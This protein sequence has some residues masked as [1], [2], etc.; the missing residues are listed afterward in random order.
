MTKVFSNIPFFRILIPFVI[1]I[2]LSIH[3][4]LQPISFLYLLILIALAFAFRVKQQQTFL[5]KRLFLVCLD[6]FF[7]LFAIN[8]VSKTNL[9][10]Q[11][12]YYGNYISS[13]DSATNLIVTVNDLPVEKERFIK[14]QVKVN[15][16]R[17]DS[18]YQQAEGSIIAYFK[19]PF[20][21][22]KLK[23]GT[24]L[25]IKAKLLEIEPPKNPYEFDYKNYLYNK[26][27]Y[28][29][30]FIDQNAFE[31]L[32]VPI[33]LNTIWYHGL[34][35]KNY[36]LQKLK[37]SALSNDA[38]GICAALLTGYDDEIDKQ[39]IESFSHSGTLHV[40]SVSGLH[41]GLI[42]L[43]LS[44]LFD[45]I[46]KKKKY[47]IFKFL[48]ITVL[49]WCFALITGFSAPVLRAVIMFNLLGFGKIFFRADQRIQVNI[50][51]V[52]AF[53]LLCY[54]PFFIT[55]VGFLL[56]YFAVFG[57]LYFQ[58][59]LAMN[60]QPQNKIV[61]WFWEGT[62][63]SF[64]ATISTLPLTLF[65][66]KQF[67]LWFFVCNII[68]VPAS[69]VILLLAFLI[70]L[71]MGFAAVVV[72]YLVSCLISFITFFNSAKFGFIDS[73][74]F[75]FYDALFL[76]ILII[77][78]SL[79]FQYRSYRLITVSFV[80]LICWQLI[81]LFVSYNSKTENLLVAYQVNK[82]NLLVVKNTKNAT[83]NT[84]DSS[85]FMYHVKPHVVS[86]NN[87]ELKV[88]DFNYIEK[89]DKH[90]LLLNKKDH[91]PDISLKEISFLILANNFKLT[92]ADLEAF[93]G[94]KTIIVDGS[95]NNYSAKKTEELCRKFDIELIK[96][97]Q[98]GAYIL[99]L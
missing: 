94:L 32:N 15:E 45:L 53:I 70:V 65:Y 69:F 40:L 93:S 18:G 5:T 20:S 67:P 24:T 89:N 74:D 82:S 12:N 99:N 91:W 72:N 4:H 46:D 13:I 23:P 59:K 36:I 2:L 22:A 68:V 19:K 49:L 56:S 21:S 51:L 97:K 88:Q 58:P 33:Q 62:T 1:G 75:G 27:I 60:W 30:T 44:F 38:Y 48:L 14:C 80:L 73:I 37:N 63:V 8:L 9:I 47:K 57:L 79:F 41:T 78:G 17:T 34:L 83:L 85:Q 52:S 6:I 87:S 25:I 16:I 71:K 95:N 42:Y 43:V 61:N 10:E 64:A 66:F 77:T 28:H 39:V 96:T 90:I 54:D 84:L 31:V 35:I 3:F 92:S 81:A 29:T 26:K 50:L 11:N 76:S 7:F 98:Q 86:F 55:D